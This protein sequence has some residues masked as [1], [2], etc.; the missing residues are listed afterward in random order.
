MAESNKKKSKK[1]E[2]L[3]GDEE[4]DYLEEDNYF[5]IDEKNTFSIGDAENSK[6]RLK[7]IL[8][9]NKDYIE[10][11]NESQKK[12]I[13]LFYEKIYKTD[14]EP[15]NICQQISKQLSKSLNIHSNNIDEKLHFFLNK[16]NDLKYNAIFEFN[17]ENLNNLGYVLAYAYR[18][19]TSLKIYTG[20]D[21]K[22][23]IEKTKNEKMDELIYYYYINYKTQIGNESN[24]MTFCKEN[25]GKFLIPGP[26]IF[27]INAF[28]YINT[29]DI[30]FNVEEEKLTKDDIN[31]FIISL[32]NIPYIFP[33][34]IT[35][36]INLIHEELQYS[37]YRRFN[38]E[39]FKKTHGKFKM[40]YMNKVDAY[41]KKWDFDTEFLLERHRKNKKIDLYGHINRDTSMNDSNLSLN[42]TN[43]YTFDR[44]YAIS[45]NNSLIYKSQR[46]K[47][48]NNGN[49]NINISQISSIVDNSTEDMDLSIP[50]NSKQSKNFLSSKTLLFNSVNSIKM[51]N[52][53]N[54]NIETIKYQSII[55]KFKNSLALMLLT[56]DSLSNFNNMKRLSLIINDAYKGEF[57]F[58]LRYNCSLENYDKL[59]IIDILINKVKTLDELNIELNIL[60]YITFQKILFFINNNITMTSI[61]ISFFSS[62]ATYLRQSIYKLYYQNIIGKEVSIAKIIKILLPHFIENLDVLFE[63]IKIK[64]FKKIE[65]NFDIPDIIETNNAY[66]NTIFKFLMN[67]LFLVDNK[68]SQIQKFVLLSPNTKFDQRYLPSIEN[69]LEDI[70][71]NENNKYLTELS[72]HL[73]LFMLKNIKNL[74]TENLVI[75][76]IGDCDLY[77]FRE[78]T[79]FLTSYKFCQ[80]SSLQYLSISLIYSI[81]KYTNEIKII[82][83]SLFSI[84]IKQLIELSVYTNIY[85]SR[86]EYYDLI[87]IFKYNWISKYRLIF[88]PKS[89]LDINDFKEIEMNNIIHLVSHFL[90]DH[91]SAKNESSN[92]KKIISKS[93]KNILDDNLHWLIN[94]IVIKKMKKNSKFIANRKKIIFN[95]LKYLYL[96]KKVVIIHQLE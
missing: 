44:N 53:P 64:D 52:N 40:I 91:L 60:D 24:I 82:F 38:K 67:L 71:F 96:T 62:D 75:L 19:F 43:S 11:N 34:K 20:K 80:K 57:K 69:I 12:L 1:V 17:K 56:I 58:F 89:E 70:N 5:K 92:R 35:I 77:T 2:N 48:N 16:K 29:I 47:Y 73:Q 61:K 3:F 26:F 4:E 10:E 15:F 50:K 76:N 13:S 51:A 41:K 27:L 18:K 45:I 95:I 7:E 93:K 72:L 66:M 90:E 8:D 85:I 39:L 36:K 32:L 46:I 65:V 31:L 86:D 42:K 68:S 55:E 23:K 54:E 88:S 21:L 6:E 63:L 84:K 49:N 37:L 81:I 22:S 25:A 87:D 83:Y 14:S 30:N 28:I 74:V 94:Q 9:D 59:H 79:K 78:L 33:S